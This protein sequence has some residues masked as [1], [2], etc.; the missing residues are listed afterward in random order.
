MGKTLR[1][2]DTHRHTD[3]KKKKKN[4]N[5]IREYNVEKE[6]KQTCVSTIYYL[7]ASLH[8]HVLSV[9]SVSDAINDLNNYV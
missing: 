5:R 3:E 9:K 6:I 2:G 7:T 1:R 4:R 8:V